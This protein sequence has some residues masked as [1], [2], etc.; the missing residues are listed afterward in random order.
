MSH[1]AGFRFHKSESPTNAPPHLV[2][3]IK[4][5]GLPQLLLH[6][7][8]PAVAH[9]NLWD[10]VG[11]GNTLAMRASTQKEPIYI[12]GGDKYSATTGGMRGIFS[13]I[14]T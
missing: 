4:T 7:A 13:A 5:L 12:H 14:L 3:E 2:K 11:N 10:H 8:K 6:V 9:M 1:T